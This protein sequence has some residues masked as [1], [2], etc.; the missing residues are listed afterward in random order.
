MADGGGLGTEG[1][2]DPSAQERPMPLSSSRGSQRLPTVPTPCN[3]GTT[4][5][6]LPL[7]QAEKEQKVQYILTP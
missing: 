6:L 4:Q 5:N 7:A 2:Q 1:S 3:A